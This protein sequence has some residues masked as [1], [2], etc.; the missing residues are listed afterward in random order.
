LIEF[1]R[2]RLNIFA[3]DAGTELERVVWSEYL[4]PLVS[5]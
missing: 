2:E 3:N 5:V 4:T 1:D